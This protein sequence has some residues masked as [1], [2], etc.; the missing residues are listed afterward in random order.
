MIIPG[1]WVLMCDKM[2]VL[3]KSW[4]RPSRQSSLV[5]HCIKPSDFLSGKFH[6]AGSISATGKWGL[7]YKLKNTCSFFLLFSFFFLQPSAFLILLST[8]SKVLY[9][10]EDTKVPQWCVCVTINWGHSSKMGESED[11]AFVYLKMKIKLKF[12][13]LTIWPC[14][15]IIMII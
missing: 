5:V 9:L 3:P 8:L 12:L 13:K 1:Y 6:N 4:T 15:F 2:G 14:L 7:L 11:N 10:L